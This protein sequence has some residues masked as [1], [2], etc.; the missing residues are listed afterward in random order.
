M[1]D[2]IT[3]PHLFC[4]LAPYYLSYIYTA[5]LQLEA[6]D[7]RVNFKYSTYIYFTTISN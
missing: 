4:F 6:S 1:K 5:Y 7:S 3:I 2:I